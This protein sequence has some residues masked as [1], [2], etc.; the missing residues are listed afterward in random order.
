MNYAEGAVLLVK[1]GFAVY[2]AVKSGDRSKTVGEVFD[3]M[4]T[5]LAEL[6]R[7]ERSH[8]PAVPEP[9]PFIE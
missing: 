4:G 5:D 6:E 8:F 7:L 3:G 2:E 9:N 1:L